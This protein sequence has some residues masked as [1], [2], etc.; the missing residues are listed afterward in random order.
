M[1]FPK[2]TTTTDLSNN[3]AQII[4]IVEHDAYQSF[5]KA[6]GPKGHK[7]V[8]SAAAVYDNENTKGKTPLMSRYFGIGETNNGRVLS[9]FVVEYL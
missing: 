3:D 6:V 2:M 1:A 5:T 4:V 8:N 7:A 9:M